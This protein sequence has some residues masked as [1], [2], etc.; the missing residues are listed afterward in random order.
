MA[1]LILIPTS[2]VDQNP[3][4][5]KNVDQNPTSCV[6]QNF[7]ACVDQNPTYSLIKIYG[8]VCFNLI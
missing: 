6:D 3:T 5:V 8:P 4:S 1:P 2:C 7:P